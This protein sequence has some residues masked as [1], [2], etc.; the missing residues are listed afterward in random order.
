VIGAKDVVV[1]LT[2]GP[3]GTTCWPWL[4]ATSAKYGRSQ[5]PHDAASTMLQCQ[6]HATVPASTLAGMLADMSVSWW[7]HM[8]DAWP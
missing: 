4:A 3:S 7:F 2:F 5:L 1:L 8:C 6:P